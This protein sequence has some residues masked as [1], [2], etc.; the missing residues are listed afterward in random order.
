MIIGTRL[1]CRARLPTLQDE[2]PRPAMT[3]TATP[4]PRRDGAPA[5]PRARPTPLGLLLAA[6]YLG[7]PAVVVGGAIDLAV[8]WATGRCIG[9]W[10]LA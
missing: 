3:R 1:K 2:R 10:C 7:L 6:L 8:Q 4:A 5:I 9:L